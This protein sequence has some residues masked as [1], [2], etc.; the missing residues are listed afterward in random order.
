MANTMPRS[1]VNGRS[2]LGA[3]LIAGVIALLTLVASACAGDDE[4]PPG[5]YSEACDRST[6]CAQG[7]VCFEAIGI[8][9][10][11]CARTQE[12]V[13]NIGS[14]TAICFNGVCQEPCNATQFMPCSN[15]LD[16]VQSG[17]GSTCQ[18]KP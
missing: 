3:H 8:C 17:G 13:T 4:T 1:S 10:Q 15:G 14:P 5:E 7:L 12:C 9:S 6:T 18:V 11:S 16:C 2:A